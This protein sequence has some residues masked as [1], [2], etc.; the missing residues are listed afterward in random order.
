M[1]LLLLKYLRY[2]PYVALLAA[3]VG[4]AI[5]AHHKG[6][7][8]GRA[9]VKATFDAYKGSVEKAALQAVTE[10][11]AKEHAAQAANEVIENEYQQKL[12]ASAGER[13]SVFRLLQQARGQVRSCSAGQATG[14]LIAATTGEAN[15]A[16]RVDRA[17][18]GVVAEGR[19]NADQLDALIAVIKPQ[20]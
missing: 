9:Q 4:G 14:A 7:A 8:A 17:V 5:Y 16:E 20:L 12:T 11:Q 6:Y 1:P 15:I 19:N 2:W 10:A 13:D 18:A 3:L